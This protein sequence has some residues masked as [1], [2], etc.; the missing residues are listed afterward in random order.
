MAISTDRSTSMQIDEIVLAAYRIAGLVSVEQSAADPTW[1]QKASF[2]KTLLSMTLAELQTEGLIARYVDFYDVDM[3]A[4][5]AA[6]TLPSDILDLVGDG[7]YTSPTDDEDS[8]VSAG[9][10]RKIAIDQWQ[11]LSNKA[12]EGTPSL[13]YVHKGT[14]GYAFTVKLWPVPDEAGNV[15][16]LAQRHNAETL[17]GTTTI[18]LETYWH[19]YLVYALAYDLAVAS[20]LPADRLSVLR[21][22]RERRRDK[23]RAAANNQDSFQPGVDHAVETH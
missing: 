5:T 3:V 14:T 12:S 8:P 9:P 17:Q 16:F 6:Y 19:K 18:D 21:N 2:G 4:G 20:S 10:V 23:C 13:Y 7:E 15:R 22:E 11:A 1:T